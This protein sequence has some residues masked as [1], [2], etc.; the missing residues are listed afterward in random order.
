MKY[1]VCPTITGWATSSPIRW[2]RRL[3]SLAT[4]LTATTWTTTPALTASWASTTSTSNKER[5]G[6]RKSARVPK[7]RCPCCNTTTVSTRVKIWM[8]AF[9]T[10]RM[11]SMTIKATAALSATKIFL[12]QVCQWNRIPQRTRRRPKWASS[13]ARPLKHQREIDPV[14]PQIK[15]PTSWSTPDQAPFQIATR[16]QWTSPRRRIEKRRN[17]ICSTSRSWTKSWTA[18]LIKASQ[19]FRRCLSVKREV[20]CTRKRSLAS[21]TLYLT[22]HSCSDWNR[23]HIASSRGTLQNWPKPSKRPW[24]QNRPKSSKTTHWMMAMKKW[25]SRWLSTT[26]TWRKMKPKQ[27]CDRISFRK[28]YS[29]W[30]TLLTCTRCPRPRKGRG[31]TA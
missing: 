26:T 19:A 22:A 27:R 15:T 5:R 21:E 16:S 2:R 6:G 8:T 14:T 20:L 3:V 18:A 11:T 4:M 12:S 23:A 25:S 30:T 13:A 28:T 29:F 7:C 24:M 31:A 1:R 17:V 9:Q 10:L